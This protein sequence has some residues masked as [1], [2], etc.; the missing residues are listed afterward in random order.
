M[1]PNDY[2]PT[3]RNLSEHIMGAL[4]SV[5]RKRE[6]TKIH[7]ETKREYRDALERARRERDNLESR[8]IT[9]TV[10]LGGTQLEVTFDS[11]RGYLCFQRVGGSIGELTG[12]GAFATMQAISK[13]LQDVNPRRIV[14]QAC[15]EDK[16]R[17]RERLFARTLSRLGYVNVDSEPPGEWDM[18]CG[19]WYI[20]EKGRTNDES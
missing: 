14:Y 11:E 9:R 2:V 8:K 19:T 1:A 13:S 3:L 17:G 10:Q 20:W 7:A 16:M 6:W 5:Q 4:R 12:A 15:G 18:G